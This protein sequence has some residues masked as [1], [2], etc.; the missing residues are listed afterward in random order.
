MKRYNIKELFNLLYKEYGPQHWWPGDTRWEIIIGAIL[1]QNTSW[2][3]VEKAIKNLKKNELL[4]YFKIKEID[5]E[6]LGTII[7][8]SGFYN[9]KAK[10]IKNFISFIEKEYN[11]DIN[12]IKNEPL[13]IAREKL[14]SVNGLGKETVDS[15]LLYAYNF[16][17]FVVDTYTK[18]IF[19]R[20]KMIENDDYEEIRSMVMNNFGDNAE[21]FN[22]FHALIVRIGKEFCKKKPL[23]KNCF[24]NKKEE[25]E[26]F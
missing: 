9:I 8:P 2:K 20:H 12:K 18:R 4:D 10:R 6:K 19:F 22:E 15:I 7:K 24:L 3:N 21:I 26:R 5:V 16:P 23:C 17:T 11:N 13:D 14:L 25:Y 1:T